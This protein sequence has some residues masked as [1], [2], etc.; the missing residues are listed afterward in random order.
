MSRAPILNASPL[1][2]HM[3][4]GP[5]RS[6]YWMARSLTSAGHL[7]RDNDAQQMLGPR[8]SPR[9]IARASTSASHPSRHNSVQQIPVQ[10][11]FLND[12]AVSGLDIFRFSSR[13]WVP[14]CF[15]STSPLPPLTHPAPTAHMGWEARCATLPMPHRP[16]Q[17]TFRTPRSPPLSAALLRPSALSVMRAP[18]DPTSRASGAEN[19]VCRPALVCRLRRRR[20]RC[21]DKAQWQR[22]AACAGPRAAYNPLGC[23][24]RLQDLLS[25]Q[26]THTPNQVRRLSLRIVSPDLNLTRSAD[27]YAMSS[28]ANSCGNSSCSCAGG[29]C[30]VRPTIILS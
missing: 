1:G 21:G 18:S 27:F 19:H 22:R 8:H 30:S 28:T 25:H 6:P 12:P 24:Y 20:R 2:H 23:R 16:P 17:R 13:L 9:W 26:P 11:R 4:V 7:S 3:N 14:H 15:R 29:T 5:R 10:L